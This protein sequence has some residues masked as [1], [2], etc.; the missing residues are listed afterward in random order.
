MPPFWDPICPP[1]GIV[2]LKA[3]LDQ[4]GYK[5]NIADFNTDGSLFRLQQKYF[6][7]AIEHFPQWKFLNIPRNG[8]RYFARHQLVWFHG[9]KHSAKY[10]ELVRQI[11]NFDGRSRC[12]DQVIAELDSII[13]E[14]FNIVLNKTDELMDLIDADMVGCTMLEST[15]PSA[16]LILKKIKERNPKTA[17]VLGGPG[18][19]TGNRVDDGNLQR[20]IE[21]CDWIDA[22]IYG[23]GERVLESYLEG[24]LGKKKILTINDLQNERLLDV[25]DIP[26][27]TYE[28]LPAIKYLWLSVFTSRGCPF[29]C[30]FCYEKDY[31]IR[32]RKKGVDRVIAEMKDLSARYGKN[33]LFYLCDSLANHIATPL[34][35]A[36]LEKKENLRWDCYMRI[37][38]ECLDENK[39]R[40]WA[41]GGMER[42]R[43]GVESGSPRVL[44]LMNKDISTEEMKTGLANF[45]KSGICTSTLW[46]AGFP[47]ERE[48]DFQVSMRFLE[49]NCR[50][51]YQA[52]I[53]E[54]IASPKKLALS[55]KTGNVFATKHLYPEEFDDLLLIKYYDQE[56]EGLSPERF[57]KISQ[58]E[59]LRMKLGIP[60]PYTLKELLEANKRWVEL[61]HKIMKGQL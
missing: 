8:P 9:H 31:W 27:P 45:A 16:L 61:G 21:R 4:R 60:N 59:K 24:A 5:V 52:D 35:K 42:A 3:Y 56:S 53:W 36:V 19:V 30:T 47:G 40:L 54:F 23:E 26:M 34:S 11:L 13:I 15:F 50:N 14:I 48:E 1:Q 22:V 2:S 32:F 10:K 49:E 33:K 46:I 17:T 28:G 29:K 39:V 43:I 41:K 57:E 18:I 20:I 37:T 7:R 25:N 51:I 38:S 12:T 58:F 55:E 6:E 44:E